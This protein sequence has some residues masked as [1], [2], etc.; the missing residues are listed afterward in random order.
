MSATATR[1]PAMSD[2]PDDGPRTI[3]SRPSGADRVFRG[4]VRGAGIAVLA[5]TGAIL[6]FLIQQALPAIRAEGFR[7]LSTSTLLY[8]SKQFGV[9]ALLPDTI[10]VAIVALAIAVPAGLAAAIYI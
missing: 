3:S 9:G 6:V 4:I 5:L 7:L 10:A 1:A 8:G 2:L